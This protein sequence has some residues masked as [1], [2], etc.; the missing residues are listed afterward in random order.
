MKK[1]MH[2]FE[3]FVLNAG[4]ENSEKV[5]RC[6]ICKTDLSAFLEQMYNRITESEQII[7]SLR[8]LI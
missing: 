7:K 2:E 1:H 4:K 5:N 6:I 8:K 3:W